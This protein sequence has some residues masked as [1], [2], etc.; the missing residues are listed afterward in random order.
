MKGFIT[1]LIFLRDVLIASSTFSMIVKV[2]SGYFSRV[3]NV[4]SAASQYR[5]NISAQ[6]DILSQGIGHLIDSP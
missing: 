2:A 6:V 5:E 1:A 4:A 3:L